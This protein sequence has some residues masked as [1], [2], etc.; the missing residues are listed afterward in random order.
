MRPLDGVRVLDFSH[1]LAGPYCTLLMADYGAAVYK[2]EAPGG[3]DMGRGWGPPFIAGHAAFFL[4]LNRGKQGISIDLKKPEGIELCLR[5]VEK[6]DVL[7]ENFRPGTMERLGLGYEAVHARHAGLVYCSISGYGQDGPARDEAAMDLIV[8]CSSGLVG[9]TGTEAGEQ[10]RCGFS[11]ADVT[12]G[13]FAAMGILMALRVRDKTG[14]GQHIDV[15]MQDCMIS[16][17]SSNYMTYLGSGVT[18]GP[19]GT[20]FPTVAPYRVFEGSDRGF[21]VAVGSDKLWSA[22]CGAIGRGEME[23]HP[24]YATNALRCVNRAALDRLLSRVFA[25]LTAAEWIARLRSAGI[26]CALVRTF[27]EVA[28][29]PQ[30]EIRGMFP[31]VGGHRVTGTPVKM[32]LTPGRADGGAPRPGEHS[33]AVLR[34][35]LDMGD[36][37]LTEMVDRGV[38]FAIV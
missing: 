7:I 11:V 13:M 19:L 1:A 33:L 3:S 35:L 27:E 18:P 16:A 8:Q 17:M 4:G 31:S 37:A 23:R 20:G 21:A 10:V 5:L 32:S 2:L 12:A 24:D 25:T 9:M 6:M 36:G 28:M 30:S 38:V 14:A 22:F 29:D 15:S 26:P 34:D